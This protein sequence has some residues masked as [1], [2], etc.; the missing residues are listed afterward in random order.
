M[1]ET[2]IVIPTYNRADVVS[3]AI[4][5]AL[6][7]TYEDFEVIVVDDG[8]TDDTSEVIDQYQDDRLRYIRYD[9]NQGANHARDIGVDHADGR[10]ISF[11][12]SD[13]ELKEDY[14]RI[15]IDRLKETSEDCVG[16]FTAYERVKDGEVVDRRRAIDGYLTGVENRG[17]VA[18]GFSTDT[19]EQRVFD[20]VGSLDE[21][22][23]SRQDLDFYI[24]ILKDYKLLG[25]D[26]DLVIHYKDGYRIS[27]DVERIIAG[28]ESLRKKH[29][30]LLPE[31]KS[32]TY[33]ARAF[34]CARDGKV[35]QAN[36][37]FYHSIKEDPTNWLAWYH[38]LFTLF[39]KR[40]FI[41]SLKLKRKGK[42][43]YK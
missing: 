17:K 18:G 28:Q 37:Y 35:S 30:D 13:D 33:Y 23:E 12:D 6:N 9:E 7:Q 32:G 11:L 42:N 39:G 4:E 25:I 14:L 27:D 15:V 3:R 5:S 38:Y 31:H 16:A 43:I 29:G 40:G 41:L 20:L 21:S 10:Y 34:A 19:F 26:D 24:R 36:T 8:S 2:S 1:P 22:L